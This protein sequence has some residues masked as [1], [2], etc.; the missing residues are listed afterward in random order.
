VQKNIQT[1]G[2]C[3]R[4]Q[5]RLADAAVVAVSAAFQVKP[6]FCA[7]FPKFVNTA[8]VGAK[9]PH[10]FFHRSALAIGRGEWYL[11]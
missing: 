5:A 4:G 9:S 3:L 2:G 1:F 8:G 11:H 10:Y 6:F 7:F